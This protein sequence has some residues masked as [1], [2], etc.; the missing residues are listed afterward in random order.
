MK[1]KGWAPD[2][3]E[4]GH[5]GLVTARNVIHGFNGYE[6]VRGLTA[7]SASLG[8]AWKGG[9]WFKGSSG[10]TA[11]L[12]GSNDGLYL[13]SASA[14]TLKYAGSYSAQWYLAQFGD[15]ILCVNGAAPLKYTLATSTGAL[16][17]GTPPTASYIAIVDPGFVFLAGN[18][19]AT[20]RVYWS[21]LEDPE[22][23]TLGTNQCDIQDLP[24]GGPVTG[25]AGGEYGIVFQDNAIHLFQYVGGA[26]IFV[27]RKISDSIGTVAHGSIA[28][29]GNRY[30]FYDQRG[31]YQLVDGQ[32]SPIGKG[33]VDRTFA[34]TYSVGEIQSNIRACVDPDRSLVFWSMPGKLWVYNWDTQEWSE[35]T[36]VGLVGITVGATSSATL[37]DIAITYP[38][39]EDV[40]VSLD[41][42]SWQGGDPVLLAVKSDFILYSFSGDYLAATLRLTRQE[43]YPGRATHVRSARIIGDITSGVS[44]SIDSRLRIG[45]TPRN[46]VSSELRASGETPIRISGRYLQ[47]EVITEAAASWRFIQGLEL[48]GAPGGRQ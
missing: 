11:M 24:D 18:S 5:D 37:E 47:P 23:W 2:L 38:A 36:I 4:F 21:G 46:V 42:A 6:P 44:L 31:F 34:E 41:D 9:G 28:Q 16:L 35:I 48:E 7:F 19:S 1:F 45:D 39:I 14:A 22:G 30:F 20:N 15:R 40:P 10:D 43:I 8:R 12:A 29:V 17:G 32:L 13:L 3:F 26:E 25:V 33:K 27:R